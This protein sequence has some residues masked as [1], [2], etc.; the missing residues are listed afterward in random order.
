M[1]KSIP[2]GLLFSRTGPYWAPGQQGFYGALAAIAEVNGSGLFPFELTATIADPEGNTDRYA[3]LC[4]DMI[5]QTGLRHVVGCITSWS[6]KEVI[7]VVE[8]ADALLWYPCVYEG[9]EASENVVYVAA[10][11]NQHLLPLLDYIVPRFGRDAFLVGSN[12]IW[13]WE[14]NRIA[15]EVLHHS[16]GEVLGE[17]YVPIGDVDIYH[18]I[19]EIRAKR[20]SFVLN[21]LIGPSSYAFLKA[22]HELGLA[23]PAFAADVRPILSCNLYESEASLVGD[24][25]AGHYT[26]SCYFQSLRTEANETFLKAVGGRAGTAPVTAFFAESYASVLLIAKA[27]REAGT[28]AIAEV[29]AA[30]KAEPFSSPF[31]ESRV[32]GRTNHV[33]MPAHIGRARADG[34]FEVVHQAL[35]AIEPDPFLTRTQLG[36]PGSDAKAS[37]RGTHLRVVQ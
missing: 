34:S 30:A 13:G 28:D 24:A 33:L 27:I 22:Y 15:R 35:Q 31:G 9:F 8:K 20:P 3:S 16:G 36:V 2:I 19:A 7:P 5:R 6:R 12:Y 37:S 32:D 25:I 21:N 23:D 11:A 18:I 1:G 4:R 17:R 26:V 14:T 29:L 10:C